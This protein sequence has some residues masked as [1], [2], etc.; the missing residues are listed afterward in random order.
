MKVRTSFVTNSSSS[1]FVVAIKQQ[2]CTK[3]DILEI[4]MEEK[5]NLNLDCIDIT[6]DGKARVLLKRVAKK[7]FDMADTPIGDVMVGSGSCS[8]E[9]GEEGFVLYN[10]GSVNTQ[11][12]V[13]KAGD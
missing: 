5:D 10:L 2:G 1:S 9:D 13:F 7:L 3:D 12:F 4:L 8:N 11:N 6:S